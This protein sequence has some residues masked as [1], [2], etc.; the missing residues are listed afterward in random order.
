MVQKRMM[1]MINNVKHF[2]EKLISLLIGDEQERV[3]G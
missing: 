2:A 1:M 3:M